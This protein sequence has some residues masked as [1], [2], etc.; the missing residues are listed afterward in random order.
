MSLARKGSRR[1]VV[2]QVA[3]RWAVRRRPTYCQAN[4]WT[5][6]RFV[7][8]RADRPGSVLV[9]SLPYAHPGNW[10]GLPSTAVRP[11]LVALAVRRALAAG[12]QPTRPGPPFTLTFRDHDDVESCGGITRGGGR[13]ADPPARSGYPASGSTDSER[14]CGGS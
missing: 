12:W 1:I 2:D 5:P 6:L 7:V 4:G 8:H 9:V 3:F 14:V 10:L 13:R 11:V